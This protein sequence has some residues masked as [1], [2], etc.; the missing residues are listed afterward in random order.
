MQ[1]DYAAITHPGLVRV[2]NEDAYL[3]SAL[4]GED[5]ILNAPV[6]PLPVGE[7]GLLLAVADGMGGAAAGEVASR[8]GLAAMAL[9]LFAHWAQQASL[10]AEGAEAL[11]A[12]RLAVASASEA[13][14]RYAQDD[15]RA[16]GMGSTLT[17][18]LLWNQK[19]HLAQ[20]GDSRAYLVRGGELF[21]LT[22]DQ[23]LVQE[24]VDQGRLTPEEARF[25]PQRNVITQALGTPQRPE[26]ALLTLDLCQGDQLLC[27]SDGLHGEVPDTR[28][29][30]LLSQGGSPAERLEALVTEALDRG[31]RDN[32]TGILVDFPDPRLPLP[33]DALNL[34]LP[35]TAAGRSSG[36]FW[37]RVNGLFHR[38][39]A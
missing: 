9:H 35:R 34:E 37:D 30:D 38:G 27:C 19:L 39:D 12:L 14:L 17:A 8:E 22:E 2:N 33:P 23:T 10:A 29:L 16:R 4:D 31:G 28:I 36:P 5:P 24:L 3:L 13:V 1:L 7:A 26:A 20:V 32:I 25:H 18:A 21:Q 15:R 11:E 6:R